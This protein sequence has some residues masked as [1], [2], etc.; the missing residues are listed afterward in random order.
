AH[1]G[2][3]AGSSPAGP[4]TLHGRETGA[5]VAPKPKYRKQPHAKQ[6]SGNGMEVMHRENTLTRRANHRHYS[7]LAPFPEPPVSALPTG[8]SAQ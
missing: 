2:L 6:T 4:T 5:V 3:V 7:S 8:A 1:N